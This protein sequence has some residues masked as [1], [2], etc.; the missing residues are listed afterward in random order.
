MKD[1]DGLKKANTESGIM[2]YSSD[3]RVQPL[4]AKEKRILEFLEVY[5]KERGIAPTY[6]DVQQHFGFKSI[7]SVQR[8]FKQLE[9][10]GYIHMPG[11]NKKRAI[12]ILQSSGAL[13]DSFEDESPEVET[14]Q[15]AP[16]ALNIPLLGRVAAGIP[17]ERM[18]HDEYVDVPVSFVRNPDR[19]YALRVEGDSMIED[20][21]FENDLLL[22]QQ[23]ADA[24][25]GEI[26]VAMVE[27]E[28]TVKRFYVHN[29][30]ELENRGKDPSHNIELRPANKTMD[31]F[32]FRGEEVDICGIVVGL[33]RQF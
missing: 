10:K 16:E 1:N 31:S 30:S 11:G 25:H 12:T 28:A 9:A 13:Q 20:G 3:D 7:N 5:M 2:D 24:R 18:E 6:K 22:V 32:W 23:Q 4:T 17:I 15:L 14:P 21:I 8:Y 33:M 29:P 26:I 19:T 27:N